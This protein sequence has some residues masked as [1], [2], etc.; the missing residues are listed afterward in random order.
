MRRRAVLRAIGLAA[1]ATLAQ[2]RAL[3]AMAPAGEHPLTET[4]WDLNAG[5]RSTPGNLLGAL[6]AARF[7]LLGEVHDNP[8]HHAIRL[9]LLDTLAG[10]SLKPAVAFEQ[11]DRTHDQALQQRLAAGEV[12]AEAVALA[13]QFDRKGWNWDLYRPLVEAALRHRMPLR[14]A[15]LSRAEASRIAKE[16]MAV[17]GARRISQLRLETVWSPEKERALRELVYEGHCRSIP[18]PLAANITAAQRARDATLAEALLEPPADGAVLIAGNGHVRRDLG[19]PLYLAQ[20][21]RDARIVSLRLRVVYASSCA[22]GSVQGSA[23]SAKIKPAPPVR[24]GCRPATA[25]SSARRA[26]R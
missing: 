17:L 24:T 21:L 18:E 20:A 4:I 12:T 13:V 3:R 10:S 26:G 9:R 1:L 8:A 7:R 22:R 2:A 6:R 19:V 11:F 14:A 5:A 15:N 16:G 25:A 23:Q